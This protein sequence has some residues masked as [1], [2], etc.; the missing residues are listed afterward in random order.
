MRR[1]SKAWVP[2][3]PSQN[4]AF[5]IYLLYYLG[6]REWCCR[7]VPTKSV[8]VVLACSVW[9]LTWQVHST[10]WMYELP[11]VSSWRQSW[12]KI[13]GKKC[14]CI[15]ICKVYK[16][17]YCSN[18]SYWPTSSIY[19]HGNH[20]TII[21]AYLRTEVSQVVKWC[22]F[23][24]QHSKQQTIT[25]PGLDGLRL[26]NLQCIPCQWFCKTVLVSVLACTSILDIYQVYFI[27]RQFVS[28]TRINYT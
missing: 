9:K 13:K 1:Y 10:C 18:S 16:G 20:G 6:C 25:C 8:C 11:N 27:L 3:A 15:C 12:S 22:H 4:N 17:M 14:V 26:I 28:F 7:S 19:I 5:W 24:S 21:S 23:G 2:S